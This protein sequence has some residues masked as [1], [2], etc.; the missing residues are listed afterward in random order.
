VVPKYDKEIYDTVPVLYVQACT[1]G[2]SARRTVKE[3]LLSAFEDQERFDPSQLPA[4]CVIT[5]NI[6]YNAMGKVDVNLITKGYVDGN[7][8]SVESITRDGK[9]SDI[10]FDRKNSE[11]ECG[12]MGCDQLFG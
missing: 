4:E 2:S 6:P 3:A 8:Y 10:R 7:V 12:G 1:Y 5:D 11:E 9:L